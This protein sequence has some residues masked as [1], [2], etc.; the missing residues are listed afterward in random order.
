MPCRMTFALIAVAA[1]PSVCDR[2][3]A[4]RLLPTQT[5]NLAVNPPAQAAGLQVQSTGNAIFRSDVK[6]WSLLSGKGITF[7]L[8]LPA[9]MPVVWKM[10]VVAAI[11]GGKSNCPLSITVN[12]K[13]VVK[14]YADT[15]VHFHPV[16]F[17]I[18]ASALQ[19]GNNTV[20]VALEDYAT[21]QLFINA[22][23]VGSSAEPQN[24]VSAGG[25]LDA[26]LYVQFGIASITGAEG[27]D[28]KAV[29]NSNIWSRAYGINRPQE[30]PRTRGQ[31]LPSL[32]L[33]PGPT[34]VYKPDD[35]FQVSLENQ[36]NK[37][38]NKWLGQFERSILSGN[39]DDIPLHVTHEVNI[40][41]DGD[42]TNLHVHGLHVDPR[43]D[44]VL[45]LI[46]PRGRRPVDL[47]QITA[48]RHSQSEDQ[49]GRQW[50]VLDVEILLQNPARPFARH[51]LVSQPQARLDFHSGRE[52]HGGGDG[53]PPQ[54]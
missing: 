14:D 16:Q 19:A 33:I 48:G 34:F 37:S 39:S 54:G 10:N 18:D 40:P 25:R 22:V 6:S 46:I 43:R 7:D 27:P 9:K 49:P 41:H 45:L 20:T 2:A 35:L 29:N 4:Q 21:T 42:N 47:Q 51:S 31:W 17:E 50:K 44:N 30:D 28:G 1:L 23:T 52:R 53:H 12:G 8:K 5:V 36:L 11:V 24:L 15:N 13:K 38:K 3:L 26:N 32:E